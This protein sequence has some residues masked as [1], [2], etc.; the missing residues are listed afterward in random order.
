MPEVPKLSKKKVIVVVLAVILGI[1][2]IGSLFEQNFGKMISALIKADLKFVLLAFG[3]QLTFFL[4]W[5]KR[6][7]I[8]LS[9]MGSAKNKIKNLYLIL[10]GS[11]FINNITPF[12][13]SGGDPVVRSFLLKKVNKTSFSVGMASSIVEY[14]PDFGI[15]FS[16]LLAGLSISIGMFSTWTAAI[17]I[18]IAILMVTIVTVAILALSGNRKSGKIESFISWIADKIKKPMSEDE[19]KKKMDKFSEGLNSVIRN[20]KVFLKILSCSVLIWAINLGILYSL[21]QAFS[22]NPPLAMLF[23]G[24]TLPIVVGMVPITPGGL[25]TIDATRAGIFLMF[26]P[27]S[28]LVVVNVV[29]LRRLIGFV[30]MIMAGSSAL[31]YLGFQIWKK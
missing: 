2:A 5:A 29:L 27:N 16:F 30:F 26:L 14:I 11:K 13:Y 8:S 9:A 22:I 12:S 4:V 10:F 7:S 6:W 28:P 18:A 31:S 3:G 15:F 23:L 19:A 17:M 21:F 20:K 25:G 24:A 1:L